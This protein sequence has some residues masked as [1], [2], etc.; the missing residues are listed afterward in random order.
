[1]LAPEAPLAPDEQLNA[2]DRE[3]RITQ[4]IKTLPPEQAELLR[5]AF[6]LAKSH[7]EIAGEMNLPL[8]TV[9]SRLR[10]AF[11]SSAQST[12]G[13][14]RVVPVH[15]PSADLLCS[16]AAG[17]QGLAVHKIILAHAS[18]CAVCRDRLAEFETIGGVLLDGESGEP[19]NP[20]ALDRALAAIGTQDQGDAVAAAPDWLRVVP[21]PVRELAVEAAR[22]SKGAPSLNLVQA[23]G[24]NRETM[25]L[26]RI[27]PGKAIPVHAHEGTE[28]SLVLTGAFRDQHGLFAQG[29]LAISDARHTHRPVAEP[30]ET[31]IALIVTTAAVRFKGPLGLLQR[32]MTLG[33]G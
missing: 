20:G 21:P 23:V 12:G 29:D 19:M 16:V 4:A 8:G 33:R 2:R 25:E 27:E 14:E 15:H 9:K 22:G 6:Y 10:L 28:Y 31:C 11:W 7:S 1:M 13:R 26:V 3:G 5:Q 32:V 18:L 30:G 17:E 24:G